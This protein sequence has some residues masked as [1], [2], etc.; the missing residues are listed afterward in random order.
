MVAYIHYRT[1][2]VM[3]TERLRLEGLKSVNYYY[4]YYYY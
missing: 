2:K 3:K 4:Y 1:W